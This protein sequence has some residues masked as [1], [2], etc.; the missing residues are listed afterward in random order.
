MKKM[1]TYL[2]VQHVDGAQIVLGASTSQAELTARVKR[3]LV[4]EAMARGTGPER[5]EEIKI[6][7]DAGMQPQ[8]AIAAVM[9]TT[10]LGTVYAA[11]NSTWKQIKFEPEESLES[12][13]V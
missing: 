10:F 12:K 6:L 11:I 3:D 4:V 7:V 1:T 9:G 8:D 5:H 2:A 13:P